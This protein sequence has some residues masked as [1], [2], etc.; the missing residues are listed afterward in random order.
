M[1]VK[2][3]VTQ[4]AELLSKAIAGSNAVIVATGFRPS[5]DITAPWKVH[6]ITSSI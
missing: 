2:A 4:G 3:D 6:A 5:I 1:Q